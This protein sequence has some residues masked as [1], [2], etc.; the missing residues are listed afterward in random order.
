MKN[1]IVKRIIWFVIVLVLAY[2][3]YFIASDTQANLARLR[4]FPWQHLPIILGAVT[5]NFLL[6]WVKWEWFRRAAGVDV[7]LGGSFLVYFSGFAMAISPGRVGELIK[8]FMYKEYF[9][10]KMRRTIP[11]VFCERISDLIGMILLTVVTAAAFAAGVGA[12]GRSVFRQGD[13]QG[14]ISVTLIQGFLAL[15]VVAMIALILGA[16]SK[17]TVYWFLFG[18]GR[19]P[20]LSG[21]A[22]KL[23]KLYFA[24][25]PLLTFR[26]LFIASAIGAV[27]WSFECLALHMILKG[28][29]AEGITLAQATFV[30]C[31][32]TIF[33]GFLFFMPGGA[34]GFEG[35][36]LAMLWMLGTDR[37]E[38]GVAIVIVRFCTLFFS[39]LLGFFF[40]L[41]TSLRY[42][43][44]LEWEEF[45]H[46]SDKA[47]A[48]E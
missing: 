27:S 11:L 2:A 22:G 47:E 43:R 35:S 37:T 13:G 5:A 48:E 20:S 14:G 6:R 3:V 31:M 32:A 8:P 24:T 12:S 10:K 45:E 7:P 16:R 39:V 40:I 17:K 30:F 36:M 41:M 4:A 44:R 21:P 42:H 1:S 46:V 28:V 33:G 19:R 38:A 34:V 23:R 25:Y 29:G 26:N 9:S 15:T 18:L